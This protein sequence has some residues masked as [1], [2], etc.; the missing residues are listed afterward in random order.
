MG[1]FTCMCV[2]V[3]MCVDGKGGCKICSLVVLSFI[4]GVM[5]SPLNP[6]LPSLSILAS[7]LL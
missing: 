3:Y 2:H 1:T 4:L 7:H 5:V 6:E